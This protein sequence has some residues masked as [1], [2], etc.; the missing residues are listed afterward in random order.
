M[1]SYKDFSRQYLNCPFWVF[2]SEDSQDYDVLVSVGSIPQDVDKA[3]DLCKFH[4]DV[5]SKS[6]LPDKPLNCNLGIFEDG[7]LVEVFKGTVDELNNCIFY[8]YKNH[9]QFYPNPITKSVERDVDEKILRVAR[10]IITFYS[11]TTLRPQIKAAL[12]GDLKLKLDVLKQ[13]DFETMREFTGK[14][15]NPEDVWKV[16]AFQFGQVFSLIDGYESDSYTKNGIIKNYPDLSPF[17]KRQ[18]L[19]D[20]D[21]EVLNQY[22]QRFVDLIESKIETI[23]L[24]EKTK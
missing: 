10:F 12:R 6:A 11:R 13:I 17:L 1:I 14:K 18:S 2:G 20:S 5:I 4:N 9:K 16:I 23:K 19:S 3:H 22:L 24:T 15:E 21:F 7:K 8:T